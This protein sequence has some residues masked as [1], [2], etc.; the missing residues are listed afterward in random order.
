MDEDEIKIEE[1][2]RE[3]RESLLAIGE[4][5]GDRPDLWIHA[6]NWFFELTKD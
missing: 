3:I 2:V 6:I 4:K 1:I 5:H